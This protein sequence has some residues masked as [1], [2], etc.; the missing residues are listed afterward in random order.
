VV[1]HVERRGMHME[2][3]THEQV[4]WFGPQNSGRGSEE[5][6]MARGGIGEFALRQS[7]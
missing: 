4:W 5:E 7:Y 2:Y 1:T 6:R 3:A